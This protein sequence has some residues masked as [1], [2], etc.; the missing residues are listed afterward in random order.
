MATVIYQPAETAEDTTR[1]EMVQTAFRAFYLALDRQAG[2]NMPSDQ[3]EP[4]EMWQ[5]GL[6]YLDNIGSRL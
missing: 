3:P 2:G 5:A 6:D 1:D 4:D